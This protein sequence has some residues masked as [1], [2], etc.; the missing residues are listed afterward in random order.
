MR[1]MRIYLSMK[2]RELEK[3]LKADGWVLDNI[4]GSHHHY[5]HSQKTGKVTVPC[6]GGDIK[7]G[8]LHSIL[9]QAGLKK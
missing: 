4:K 8:T 1:I 3:L 6:H 2:F 7:Q 9:R 5:K